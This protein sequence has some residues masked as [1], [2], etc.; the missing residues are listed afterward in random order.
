M[1]TLDS[2][3]RGFTRQFVQ[4]TSVNVMASL[5]LF[6]HAAKYRNCT[7]SFPCTDITFLSPRATPNH[8]FL[9]DRWS[10][11]FLYLAACLFLLYFI[12]CPGLPELFSDRRTSRTLHPIEKNHSLV[13]K[14]TITMSVYISCPGK[15]TIGICGSF[16]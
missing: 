7:Q 2:F 11:R 12:Y 13:G 5:L 6:L 10:V 15:Y 14:A 16:H 4:T 3:P 1:L 8:C 9:P